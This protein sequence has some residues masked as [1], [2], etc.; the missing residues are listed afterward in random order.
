MY[1]FRR[2]RKSQVILFLW[3]KMAIHTTWMLV[4]SFC[5][6]RKTG[7]Y[8]VPQRRMTFCEVQLL[9]LKI[10]RVR[11]EVRYLF[12]DMSMPIICRISDYQTLNSHRSSPPI[13][14]YNFCCGYLHNLEASALWFNF[15]VM[16]Y[17]ELITWELWSWRREWKP[18]HKNLKANQG[19]LSLMIISNAAFIP[20]RLKLC[21]INCVPRR[22]LW[23]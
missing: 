2:R 16:W 6:K 15:C 22:T 21:F 18:R 19:V 11:V 13:E 9:Y 5:Y 20:K 7:K 3:F 10:L 23:F 8:S 12:Q 4:M 14:L 1:S 17:P